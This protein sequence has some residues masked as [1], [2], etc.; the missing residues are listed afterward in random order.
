MQNL[1]SEF[2]ILYSKEEGIMER[3][4]IYGGTFNPP[5]I[6]HIEAAKQAVSALGLTKLLLIPDRIAPHKVIPEG[7]AAPNQRL[8]MLQLAVADCPQIQVSD[9]ELQREGPSYTYVTLEQLRAQYPDAKLYLLMGTDMF[10]SFHTW[11]NPDQ[12]LKYVDLAVFYL[13][14]ME[15]SHV[16]KRLKTEQLLNLSIFQ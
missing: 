8:E 10:L 16:K 7:T 5:H 14:E 11:K 2:C 3:I 15:L 13:K 4:G 9:I 6:G 1:F 12:I